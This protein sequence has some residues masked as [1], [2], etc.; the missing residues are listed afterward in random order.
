MNFSIFGA[1]AQLQKAVISFFMFVCLSA[2]N[3]SA[4]TPRTY[5]KH[6]I[7]VFCPKPVEKILVPLRYDH[8]FPGCLACPKRK[9]EM[10]L[11]SRDKRGSAVRT[12]YYSGAYLYQLLQWKKTIKYYLFWECVCLV[13]GIQH[14]KRMRP[15]F[16]CVL[17]RSTI[18]FPHYLINSTIWVWGELLNIKWV[19]VKVKFIQ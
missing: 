2:C 4:P 12:T 18:F 13:L 16:I 19:K 14:A 1:F 15:I 5:N 10:Q 9:C 8:Y 6:D 3:S 7:W 17:P 11:S